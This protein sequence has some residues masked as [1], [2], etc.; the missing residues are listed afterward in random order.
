MEEQSE[1]IDRENRERVFGKTAINSYDIALR[2]IE[3]GFIRGTLTIENVPRIAQV[4]RKEQWIERR[5]RGGGRVGLIAGRDEDDGCI[6]F[7]RVR[8]LHPQ[9]MN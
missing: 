1:K 8:L 3:R 9:G 7:A 4:K 5:E 2:V 6:M